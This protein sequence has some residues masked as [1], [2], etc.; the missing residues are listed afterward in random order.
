L[1][2]RTVSV[3][4]QAQVTGYLQGMDKAAKA[5]AKAGTEAEKAQRKLEAQSQAMQSAGKGLMAVGLVAV[6]A[7]AL[8]VKAAI[9]WETAW[10]GVTKTVEGTP[11]ELAKVE[12]GLRSLAKTLP[13]SHDQIAAVAEA[14]GQLGIQTGSVTA[15]TKT[16]IDLGETTNLSADEAATSLAR[17][18]NI[19][20]TAQGDVDRLG[21][22]IVA[23][24][25]NYATTEAEIV[26]M[27][28]RLAGAGK[29]IGLSEGEVLGLSTALS[30]VGIEAEA[31][32][33]AFSKVMIDISASVDEGGDRL[34]M[35]A[36]ASGVSAADFTK[37]W[38]N[39]PSAALSLFV[40]GLGDAEKQGGSTLETLAELGI[41][42]VRMRDALL[43][44]SSASDIFTSAM[45]DGNTAF[46][47]NNALALE[48]AKR[49]ATVESQLQIMS[50]RVSDAAISFGQV[51][52]PAVSA[53]ADGIG[54]LADAL[55]D[56]D[57]VMQGTVAITGL[58]LGG[59]ALAGGAFLI[60]IPKA[61]A[62][63][64]SLELLN[65]SLGKV[66]L[67]TAAVAGAVG[68]AIGV[69]SIM[70]ARQAEA[71]ARVD[72]LTDS[73]DAN[74]GSFT[75]NTRE[76]V[77]NNLEKSDAYKV[78]KLMGISLG[79]LA[80]AALGEADAVKSV[81][82][83]IAAQ[84][85]Q[86][87]GFGSE[88][89]MVQKSYADIEGAISGTSGELSDAREKWQTHKEAMEDGTA[90]TDKNAEATRSAADAY[91][92]AS[93]EAGGLTDTLDKL[94]EAIDEVNGM[95]QDA[96]S[97]NARFRQ[98]LDEISKTAD[99]ASRSLDES[100]AAGSANAAA[101][102][103]V[104]AD[105]QAAAEAQ[106]ELDRKTMGGKEATEK[107]ITT[108][109]VSREELKKAATAAGYNADEVQNL[110][111]KVLALP[112]EHQTEIL[113]DTAAATEKIN[114]FVRDLN[115]IPGRRDVV[116]NQVVQQTG[117]AH[118]AVGAAYNAEGGT[119]T[120]PGTG[121]SDSILSWVSNGEEI[122]RASMAEKY[123]P[124]LKAINADRLGGYATGGT[125]GYASSPQYAPNPGNGGSS[126]VSVATQVSLAGATFAATIDGRPITMMIQ[127]QMV[128]A[129]DARDGRIRRG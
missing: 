55:G 37:Q 68:L 117:A 63:K 87:K 23:L 51:F 16:M 127:E 82:D 26:A 74:T 69:I 89:S 59:V 92:E 113:A 43:R 116:I 80:D 98:S 96:V 76:Q 109:G 12:E 111:D 42:E 22:V 34:D 65:I 119:I 78:A 47:E 54:G 85:E 110:I 86:M 99:D 39:D 48:A 95:N 106:Y 44:A 5:T 91:V 115:N 25:N 123:R 97:T 3:S 19:M 18:M 56:M 36:K 32:G 53:A 46:E 17:F 38:K 29:Q 50:N 45:G 122:I 129:S 58:V 120:G 11:A 66:A 24:G 8:S 64:A 100:S 126:A 70:V 27:S 79:E 112:T 108:L 49:Y 104:A 125:V 10:T 67:S 13:A 60:A 114:Q 90:A 31:G 30:S 118:G 81:T 77:V 41:T 84:R 88:S 4:L 61:A 105:A 33:S 20:G 107:Y 72:G 62:F 52:L 101:L 94:L 75:K 71:K 128:S 124:L 1:A 83:K 35:F 103:G 73:L 15:F 28:M 121:T 57:P 7:T 14:A 40:E 6:A 21:S 9:G 102:A 93:D 2:D